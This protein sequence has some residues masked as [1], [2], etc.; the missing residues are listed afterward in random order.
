MVAIDFQSIFH[1]L[2]V[3]GYRQLYSYQHSSK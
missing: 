1:T 3:N 2:E